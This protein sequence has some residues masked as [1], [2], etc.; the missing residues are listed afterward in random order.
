M[1][2]K[3]LPTAALLMIGA[4]FPLELLIFVTAY[5]FGMFPKNR[6][7]WGQI[8]ALGLVRAI[9]QT[10]AAGWAIFPKVLV[11]WARPSLFRWPIKSYVIF[12]LASFAFSV[13][14]F[15]LLWQTFPRPAGSRAAV[16]L[17][18]IN[19]LSFLVMTVVLSFRIDRRLQATTYDYDEG[20]WL[21]AAVLG[22]CI[23]LVTALFLFILL[24]KIAGPSPRDPV[25]MAIFAVVLGLEAGLIGYFV[26]ATAAAHLEVRVVQ[27]IEGAK[28]ELALIEEQRSND[29]RWPSR[30]KAQGAEAS[31]V[32][33]AAG[34]RRD[35]TGTLA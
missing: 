2:P 30:T 15:F 3:Q 19:A 14:V 17:A 10:A 1:L 18:L 11:S 21:D 26:P 7:D 24:P 16:P 22:S 34:A 8:I 12:G 31:L 27:A 29:S 23:A 9:C 20:R 33:D 5:Q 28:A 13:L 32:G 6:W 25:A 35:A 4:I